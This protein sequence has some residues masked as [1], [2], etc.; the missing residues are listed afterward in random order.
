MGPLSKSE[1][2]IFDV[3][4]SQ[5]R[6]S[7]PLVFAHPTVVC[8]CSVFCNR[9]LELRQPSELIDFCCNLCSEKGCSAC[10]EED[11]ALA[12]CPAEVAPYFIHMVTSK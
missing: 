2:I 6:S 10:G 9:E 4:Q 1:A 5:A 7:L 12:D 3:S 8:S 11:P